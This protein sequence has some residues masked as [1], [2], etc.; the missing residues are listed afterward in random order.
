MIHEEQTELAVRLQPHSPC[1][2]VM[3]QV[4]HLSA[5][6]V[7]HQSFPVQVFDLT[8]L[9][10]G[11]TFRRS[12]AELAWAAGLYKENIR[13]LTLP[14]SLNTCRLHSYA[15]MSSKEKNAFIARQGTYDLLYLDVKPLGRQ[16]G[17]VILF[18][19]C[20]FASPKGK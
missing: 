6:S 3:S 1:H 2:A 14:P 11:S 17:K 10:L 8:I 12:S 20:L 18:N 4:W 7:L 19:L 16:K 13:S 9:I 5:V 15:Y